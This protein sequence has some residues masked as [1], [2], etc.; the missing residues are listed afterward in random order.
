MAIDPD[1]NIKFSIQD[2]EAIRLPNSSG[3][4]KSRIVV[5]L[6][7]SGDQQS[8][9]VVKIACKLL[10]D[11]TFFD[12]VK[13]FFGLSVITQVNIGGQQADIVLNVRSVA[14]RLG[15]AKA[16]VLKKGFSLND[17]L[18]GPDIKFEQPAKAQKQVSSESVEQTNIEQPG[19]NSSEKAGVEAKATIKEKVTAYSSNKTKGLLSSSWEFI[20]NLFF[21]LLFSYQIDEKGFTNLGNTCFMNS[22][23]RLF[24]SKKNIE[25][26]I[27]VSDSKELICKSLNKQ[28]RESQEEYAA[29]QK[30]LSD[31]VSLH[32]EVKKETSNVDDIKKWLQA[33]GSNP[34]FE[35]K[36][37]FF[38]AQE[39]AHEFLSIVM[40]AL[41]LDNNTSMSLKLHR[42]L[43]ES[44]GTKREAGAD[45]AFPIVELYSQS[46]QKTNPSSLVNENLA[47]EL[48]DGR[49]YIHSYRH[50]NVE[51]LKSLMIRMPRFDGGM[52]KTSRPIQSVFESFKIE[53]F[54]ESKQKEVTLRLNPKSAVCHLGS[55]P[56]SGHYVVIVKED[57][58]FFEKS[59]LFIKELTKQEAESAAEQKVYL[60]DY[61]VEVVKEE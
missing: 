58:K 28:D 43:I 44:D 53:V 26:L 22:S 55:S 20:S 5:T 27:C 16:E 37:S 14:N 24:L 11:E 19:A 12:T 56:T 23:I 41:E 2:S 31:I 29:R 50:H 32:F 36:F 54:D 39:D 45:Q 42:D 1:D 8:A 40:D 4:L 49:Q 15:I 47:I 61:D 51:T 7:D 21:S 13:R 59:D 38:E 60:V 9:R 17:H 48:I 18:K 10:K 6:N 35:G 57:G 34:I 52:Q 25:D 33:I 3:N 46:R 30:L